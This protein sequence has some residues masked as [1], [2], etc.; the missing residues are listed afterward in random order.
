MPRQD[1]EK[2]NILRIV[3]A[4][5]VLGGEAAVMT[6]VAYCDFECPYCR[7]AFDVIKRLQMPLKDRLRYVFRHFPLSQKHPFA[8]EAAELAEAA[9][10]QGKFWPIHDFLFSHQDRLQPDDVLEYAAKVGLDAD[11]LKHDVAARV[12][13]E[14][15]TQDKNGGIRLGVMGTPT[16]F[17]NEVRHTD[18]ETLE[19]LLRRAA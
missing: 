19:H 7:R 5:H 11:R 18:E 9:G 6:V 13:A 4:D 3:P 1:P 16:F 12:Y 14:R 15:V 2:Q 8:Q 17:L 10:A